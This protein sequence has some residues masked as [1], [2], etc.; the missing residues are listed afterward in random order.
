VLPFRVGLDRTGQNDPA[1]LSDQLGVETLLLGDVMRDGGALHVKAR[2]WDARAG[3]DLWQRDFA[4]SEQDLR[5]LRR[6]IAIALVTGLQI[7]IGEDWQTQLA[8]DALTSSAEAY[9]RYLHARYLLRWR[10]P[11]T[12]ERAAQDLRDA[13]AL[14]PRFAR[15][16]AALAAVYALWIPDVPSVHGDTRELSI[17]SAHRALVLE[18]RLAEAHAVLGRHASMSGHFVDAEASFRRA[19]DADPRDPSA[20]H[21]YTLHLYSVGRLRDAL[22]TQRRSVALDATSAQPMM[23]L[24][25][26]TTLRGDRAEALH[27]WQKADDMGAARPLSAAIVRLELGQEEELRHW[28]NNRAERSGIPERM[29]GEEI[30]VQGALDASQREAAIT[31]LRKVE[32]E[33]DP[34]FAITHYAMLGAVDDAFRVAEGYDLFDDRNYLLRPANLWAPRTAAFR[35]DP[36]FV[37]LAK[38][39]G[40]L[41]YWQR[42]AVSDLCTLNDSGL[43]CE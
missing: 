42:V 38:R 12:L 5:E 31:W 21:F 23:W 27:L 2:L 26:L 25:M 8:P 15:A 4:T 24:A 17:R 30:L 20:L 34:P 19:M 10:R 41:D 33:V 22:G 43:S 16:H 9:R 39:W 29:D 35:R 11:E 37:A 14:D 3:R 13:I 7:E 32:G 6:Q 36:R 18:P 1:A 28:Y 40:L